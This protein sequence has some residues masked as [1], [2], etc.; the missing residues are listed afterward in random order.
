[1]PP[2]RDGP[3]RPDDRPFPG[4]LC[5]RCAHHRA[6]ATPRSTFLM[7]TALPVKYP[8]QP[9]LACGTFRPRAATT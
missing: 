7:C 4:S 9:V 1:M 6:I 8:P 2:N 3:A 5:W